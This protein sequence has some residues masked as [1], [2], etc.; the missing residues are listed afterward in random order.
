MSRRGLAG[1]WA[2]LLGST[3]AVWAGPLDPYALE[4][5][6]GAQ[7]MV[8]RDL[9]AVRAAL[10]G[11]PA[12]TWAGVKADLSASDW[13]S[14]V[15]GV[16]AARED[17][18]KA[19]AAFERA[20][21]D[22]NLVVRLAA[23]RLVDAASPQASGMAARA[24]LDD[25]AW[26]REAG[27]ELAKTWPLA[28]QALVAGLTAPE[29]ARRLSAARALR[30]LGD[31]AALAAP[32][33]VPPLLQLVEDGDPRIR[34]EAVT[35]LGS[36]KASAA[37]SGLLARLK[38]GAAEVRIA[39]AEGLG[40]IGDPSARD[41]LVAALSDE[42]AGHWAAWSLGELGLHDALPAIGAMVSQR[43]LRQPSWAAIRKLATVEDLD[44]LGKVFGTTAD[45]V[46]RLVLAEIAGLAGPGAVDKLMAGL[47]DRREGVRGTVAVGLSWCGDPRAGTALIGALGDREQWIR[48]VV[49]QSLMFFYDHPDVPAA[50]QRMLADENPAVRANGLRLGEKAK[51]LTPGQL[52]RLL[53]EPDTNVSWSAARLL[54]EFGAGDGIAA[55]TKAA[56]DDSAAVRAAAAIG[57][58]YATWGQAGP[59]LL[60]LLA[61]RDEQ[62]TVAAQAASVLIARLDRDRQQRPTARLGSRSGQWDEAVR[63]GVATAVAPLLAGRN[64]G[65]AE[66]AAI[67]LGLLGKADEKAVTR[68]LTAARSKSARIR[69]QAMTALGVCRQ[70]RAAE[71]LV[72]WLGDQSDEFVDQCQQALVQLGPVALPA[73]AAGLQHPDNRLRGNAATALGMM[74]PDVPGVEGLLVGALDNTSWWVR[75]EAAYGLARRQA[76]GVTQRIVPLLQDQE[77]FCRRRAA[78]ALALLRDPSAT[79]ALLNALTDRDDQVKGAAAVAL[80]AIGD[81]RARDRLLQLS[82]AKSAVVAWSALYG[83]G[84]MLDDTAVERLI[85]MAGDEEEGVRLTACRLL[86]LSANANAEP[87]LRTAL[88][89]SYREARAAAAEALGRMALREAGSLSEILLRTAYRDVVMVRTSGGLLRGLLDLV[90]LGIPST[91]N[92]IKHGFD[93]RRGDAWESKLRG[94]TVPAQEQKLRLGLAR[95]LAQRGNAEAVPELLTVLRNNGLQRNVARHHRKTL[96]GT[97]AFNESE[98]SIY[99]DDVVWAVVGALEAITGQQDMGRDYVAWTR[100]YATQPRF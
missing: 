3:A 34:A 14:R 76:A 44:L 15:A 67:V 7:L 45:Y 65:A 97:R 36:L 33:A 16:L 59:P 6:D 96:F 61:D 47:N 92:W 24:L 22:P 75:A 38:D 57:L 85:A 79:E 53:A 81:E 37:L 82:R 64:G 72:S 20:M 74:P 90:T 49:S 35:A 19:A 52:T 83:L 30:E 87:A 50:V 5:V 12:P 56:G 80:G 68:L 8:A 89:D 60:T 95:L 9:E 13:R 54:V 70:P 93:M 29:A 91:I 51:A 58:S 18:A 73:L 71:A 66:S 78:G 86:G 46:D 23:V 28:Q 100:W 41:G 48:Q 2:V 26:V 43:G 62:V 88:G 39:A 17:S 31:H 21:A 55:L 1:V 98:Q 32:E 77:A 4:A 99:D 94:A 27:A 84:L 10:T 42:Q 11:A 40:R 25:C 63:D 69:E